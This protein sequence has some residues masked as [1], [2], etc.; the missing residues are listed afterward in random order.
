MPPPIK[1]ENKK[2]YPKDW[3]K[4]RAR[5][6]ARARGRCEHCGASNGAKGLQDLTGRWHYWFAVSKLS[7]EEFKRKFGKREAV[8]VVIT[9]AHL[10]HD[11]ANNKPR[12]LKALC[13]RCHNSHDAA[14]RAETRALTRTR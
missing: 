1:A 11:P 13:Q 3:L 10:D 12:N 7:G 6:L 4:I 14:H 5:I 2:L 9:I 8:Q